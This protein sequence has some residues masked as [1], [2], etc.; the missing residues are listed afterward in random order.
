MTRSTLNDVSADS[1]GAPDGPVLVNL[2]AV[3]PTTVGWLWRD[4]IARGKL[5][6][7]VGEVGTGKTHVALDI[8]ARISTGRAWPD[9][10]QAP[11]GDV[12]LL[13]SEDGIADTVRPTIDKQGGDPSRIHVL[14]AVRF[15]DA[16]CPFSLDRDLSALET[17]IVQT[18]AI[19]VHISPLSAYLGAKDSYKDSEIRGLL[20]PLA[21]MA[22]RH[23][24]ALFAILHL[25]KAQT[26]KLI[27]RAQ[28]S[29]AFV[30]QARTVLAVGVTPDDGRRLMVGVKNNHGALAAGLAFQISDA[31]LTWES[32]PIVGTADA[33]LA[34]DSVETRSERQER[35]QAVQFLRD[36]LTDGP[37]ASRE[38]FADAKANGI[39]QR[40]LWR[41]KNELRIACEK[42][43][44]RGA[45]GAWFWMLPPREAGT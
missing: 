29:I 14:Q 8:A 7:I 24:S 44:G 45:R 30:A 1:T 11:K 38:I 5:T 13:T 15:A 39:A 43:R 27:L 2:A 40:T 6:L 26:S 32:A 42:E 22:E 9:G 33:L 16:E 41:A 36:V 17:A 21:A 10:D 4:R 34:S 12:I 3:E 25:T 35:D 23:R 20:T 37:L 19:A 28:G 31:G 18:S